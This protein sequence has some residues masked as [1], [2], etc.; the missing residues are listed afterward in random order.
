[1][2]VTI[3]S[4]E[5]GW[6]PWQVPSFP[7]LVI[8][9]RKVKFNYNNEDYDGVVNKDTNVKAGDYTCTNHC[10][11]TID[12]V[13]YVVLWEVTA[14]E[15]PGMEDDGCD[16][17]PDQCSQGLQGNHT[18]PFKVMGSCYWTCRQNALEKGFVYLNEYNR[19]VYAKL[20]EEPENLT[21]SNAI[22]VY[23]AFDDWD[24]YKKV[25][26]IAKELTVFLKPHLSSLDVE[27]SHIRF[28]TTYF[29]MG[30]YMTLNVTKKGIWHKTVVKAS[31]NVK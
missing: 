28:C 2:H 17:E 14:A 18:L 8:N 30:Y 20:M 21:D 25:G 29:R 24:E 4:L 13:E 11:I 10:K 22:A 31:K 7:V 16:D 9:L 12:D 19:P 15:Q 3:T 5:E 27:V 6:F 23:I 26:Y 1:M